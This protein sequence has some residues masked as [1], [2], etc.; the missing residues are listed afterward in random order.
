[1]KLSSFV[2]LGHRRKDGAD[3]LA[4]AVNQA[5]VML[6]ENYEVSG[7]SSKRPGTRSLARYP[8]RALASGEGT[9]G[10]VPWRRRFAPHVSVDVAPTVAS[11]FRLLK[12]EM[13]PVHD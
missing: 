2:V 1:M 13:V 6:C 11:R 4:A 8:A 9:Q 3:W 10:G 12:V 7:H 5:H